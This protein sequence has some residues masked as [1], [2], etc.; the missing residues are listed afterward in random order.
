MVGRE[1]W[2]GGRGRGREQAEQG[3]AEGLSGE[4]LVP[5]PL[6]VHSLQHCE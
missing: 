2:E 1:G 4:S 3:R 5:Q 6:P